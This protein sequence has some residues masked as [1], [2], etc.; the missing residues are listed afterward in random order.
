MAKNG[1]TVAEL[2]GAAEELE[3]ELARLEA[4][5]EI[6]L[7]TR[8]DSEKN[9]ARATKELGE[10]L[11]MP[12]RLAARLGALASAMQ[13]MQER[14][15]AALDP[16]AARSDAILERKR[17]LDEHVRAYAALGKATEDAI[18]LL[19]SERERSLV[20]EDLKKKL[21]TIAD[22]AKTLFEAARADDFP[23]IARESDT[24]SKRAAALILRL[25]QAQE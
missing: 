8:L 5:S 25:T 15:K 1:K 21:A 17:R 20:V 22:D 16:L 10:A 3:N 12:E 6:A 18:E 23:E 24:L 14:Q 13:H 4:L 19:R 11:A 2:V 7:K 9:I